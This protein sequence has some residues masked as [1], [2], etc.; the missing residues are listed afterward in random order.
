[1]RSADGGKSGRVSG[2][3]VEMQFQTIAGGVLMFQI[4]EEISINS[5]D[6]PEIAFLMQ[7][8]ARG[9]RGIWPSLLPVNPTSLAA[10]ISGV[11]IDK[12]TLEQL[13]F[14]PNE[15]HGVEFQDISVLRFSY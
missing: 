5:G 1:M 3:S 9:K 10:F 13:G 11:V 15:W 4:A 12:K 2:K 7:R 6:L 8:V 14:N